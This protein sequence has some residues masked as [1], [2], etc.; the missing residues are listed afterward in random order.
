[1]LSFHTK[2]V[3]FTTSCLIV[4]SMVGIMLL[5]WN[6]VLATLSLKGKILASFFQSV[7]P[8]TAGFNTVD[9]GSMKEPT[10]LLLI[11]LMFIGASP[12]GTGGGVKTTTFYGSFLKCYGYS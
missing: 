12:G 10:W 1:M 3:L 7:T 11:V 9:I 6:N 8:R 2:V 5:E 4:V